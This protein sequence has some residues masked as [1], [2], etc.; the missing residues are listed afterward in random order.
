MTKKLDIKV[1]FWI[2]LALTFLTISF[3]ERIGN[4]YIGLVVIDA[5]L[6]FFMTKRKLF[7]NS[8]SGNTL[9]AVGIGFFGYAILFVVYYFSSFIL[10]GFT[11]IT[12]GQS[13]GQ[14]LTQMI[15]LMKTQAALTFESSKIFEIFAIGIL[16]PVV[17]T[18]VFFGSIFDFLAESTNTQINTLKNK[19][20]WILMIVLSGIF[21]WFHVAVRGQSNVGWF[22]TFIFGM[23]SCIMVIKTK[24][25]ESAVWFHVINN[26]IIKLRG[27]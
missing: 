3:R 18:K 8:I 6:L 21:T 22:I 2:T 23:I 5:L 20:L 12:A 4:V 13:I 27:G 17:E 16:I 26:M 7:L 11:D 14:A 9:K 19:R 25:V 10:Q 1:L 24:E 15:S